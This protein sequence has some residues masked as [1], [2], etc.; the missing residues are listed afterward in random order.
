MTYQANVT[1]KEIAAPGSILSDLT[2]IQFRTAEIEK[3]IFNN[4]D[5]PF[6]KFYVI[7]GAELRITCNVKSNKIVTKESIKYVQ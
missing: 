5:Q 1:Y 6:R 4:L 2:K 7:L 3:K